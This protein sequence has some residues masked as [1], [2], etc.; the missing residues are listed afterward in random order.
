MF[1][2]PKLRLIG[3]ASLLAVI[4]NAGCQ[5]SDESTIERVAVSG[6]VTLD[7]Q[8]LKAGAIIFR[9]ADQGENDSSVTAHAFVE[10]GQYHIDAQSGPAIGSAQVLFRPKPLSR[11][12]I[13][14]ALD[15]STSRR[16]PQAMR[17]PQMIV[18]EIPERYGENSEIEVELIGGSENHHDFKLESRS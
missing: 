3:I 1:A 5:P 7:G 14:G 4:S 18:V 13:E 16:K 17:K 2:N 12:E 11:E 10:D 8:P 6:S 9:N 15:E